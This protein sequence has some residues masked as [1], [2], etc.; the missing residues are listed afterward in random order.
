MTAFKMLPKTVRPLST[1]DSERLRF[2]ASLIRESD[3]KK[4]NFILDVGTG[5]GN[6]AACLALA[7]GKSGLVVSVDVDPKHRKNLI[8]CFG[9]KDLLFVCCDARYLPFKNECFDAAASYGTL[10]FL[11]PRSERFKMLIEKTRVTKPNGRVVTAEVLNRATNEAEKNYLL[12]R[13]VVR[14]IIDAGGQVKS[15]IEPPSIKEVLAMYE[16][17]GLKIVK[18]KML[19]RSEH[20]YDQDWLKDTEQAIGSLP[21]SIQRKLKPLITNLKKRTVRYGV[22]YPAVILLIG[23]RS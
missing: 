21:R 7:T 3:I 23:A 2:F 1:V 5:T 8:E 19:R 17:T 12:K 13:K 9:L 20:W 18:R 6:S 15:S 14:E 22:K 11:Y 4:G 10:K 16:K